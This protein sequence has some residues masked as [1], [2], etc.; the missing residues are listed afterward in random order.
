MHVLYT[1]LFITNTAEMYIHAPVHVCVCVCVCVCLCVCVS[2]YAT[3]IMVLMPASYY[4][5]TSFHYNDRQKG[6]G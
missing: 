6:K 4:C 3:G 1:F 2:S 5:M